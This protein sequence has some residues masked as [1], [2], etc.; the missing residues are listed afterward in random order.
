MIITKQLVAEKVSNYLQH[1]ITLAE[2]VDWAEQAMINESFYQNDFEVIREVVSYLGLADV[3]AFG[4][5][6]EDCENLLR[7]LGYVIKVEIAQ[8]A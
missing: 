5:Q 6:L 3:R 8:V 2:L 1:K 4:L 7:K